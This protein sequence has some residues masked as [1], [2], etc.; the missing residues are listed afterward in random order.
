MILI[1]PQVI[2]KYCGYLRFQWSD[3]VTRKE[4]SLVLGGLGKSGTTKF[5][6]KRKGEE[7]KKRKK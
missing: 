5:R 3:K 1:R 6:N 7:E 4:V 2:G